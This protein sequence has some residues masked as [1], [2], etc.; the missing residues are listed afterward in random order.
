MGSSRAERRALPATRSPAANG[1]VPPARSALLQQQQYDYYLLS[2]YIFYI[3]IILVIIYKILFLN[4][5]I[6]ELI[7]FIYIIME[8]CE[9]GDMAGL[10]KKCKKSK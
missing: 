7:A 4:C 2:S 1:T 9:Q 8:Y 3:K 10:I 5:L 6:F